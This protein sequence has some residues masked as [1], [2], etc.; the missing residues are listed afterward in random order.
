MLAL[1]LF[2][3]I[4]IWSQVHLGGPMGGMLSDEQADEVVRYYLNGVTAP[5]SGR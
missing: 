2:G 5:S 3:L 4:S 1:P